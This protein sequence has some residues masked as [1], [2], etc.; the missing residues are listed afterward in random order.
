M[1]R[2]VYPETRARSQF[3]DCTER[4]Y[5]PARG[6]GF[7]SR[8]GGFRFARWWVAY[9]AIS[10][11]M[12]PIWRQKMKLT[13]NWRKIMYLGGTLVASMAT[14]KKMIVRGIATCWRQKNGIVV[15]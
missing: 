2:P 14:E 12:S 9:L 3:K 1:L 11:D 10:G 4:G 8:G 7:Q 15:G 13:L 6:G 5:P